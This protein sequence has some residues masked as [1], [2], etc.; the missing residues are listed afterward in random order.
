M[1]A[2]AC[3]VVTAYRWGQRNAHSYVV[4]AYPDLNRAKQCAE[5][6]VDYRGGKYACEVVQAGSWSEDD[7]R[8]AARQVY[9]V[10]SPYYGLAHDAGH[11]HPA[12]DAKRGRPS[13]KPFTVRELQNRVF[14]LERQLAA[15]DADALRLLERA[16]DVLTTYDDNAQFEAEQQIR[17]RIAELQEAKTGQ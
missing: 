10:E 14:E 5:E 4:G 17:A 12:D 15:R 8:D 2:S 7:E 11:F 3:Y 1:S 16:A 6:H 9:Y 13:A